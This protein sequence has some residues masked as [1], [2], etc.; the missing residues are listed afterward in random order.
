MLRNSG[1][2]VY[3]NTE[4]VQV[5]VPPHCH[6]DPLLASLSSWPERYGISACELLLGC[7]LYTVLIA[8]F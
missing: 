2:S 7:K 5:I 1:K 3:S 8:L 4:T 6:V